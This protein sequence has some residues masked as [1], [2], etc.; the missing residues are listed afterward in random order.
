MQLDVVPKKPDQLVPT[1]IVHQTAFWGS[2]HR[3]LGFAVDAFDLTLRP[4]SG[5]PD[6]SGD[7]L[8]MRLPLAD[9][10]EC[11]YV[12][13]GPEIAPDADHVGAFL[14]G[15]SRE[16]RP[17][18]GERCAFI[19]WDLPWT[20][21][22]ARH[23]DDFT[24]DGRWRGAPAVH[25]REIRMNFGTSDHNLHKAPRD[26]LPPD[27]LLI[28][29]DAP[30]DA[31][32][33]RMHHKTRYNVRL[34]ERHGVVVEEGTLADLPAWHEIYLETARRCA[35]EPLP[36]QHFR[37]LLTERA[38]GAASPVLSRLLLARLDGKLLAGLI[39]AIA[40]TR[41]TYL[42][43]ASTR[44]RP[45]AM[46]PH[47]VQW[48]AIRLARSLGCAEY[49]MFGVAPHGDANHPLA[50]VHRFKIGF[51]GRLVHREGC[52]DFPYED[53]YTDL[54]RWE[55]STILHRTVADAAT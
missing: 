3:R 5:D 52:W 11:A 39:L 19:R 4:S 13:F 25:L 17:M 37:A 48:A 21:L 6:A 2:V 51:G 31:L 22:H 28:D 20:S 24:S 45:D 15:L 9:G 46:A 7:F 29:L 16:L 40:P 30:E 38:A 1:P 12:P 42:Y 35:I 23:A 44:E 26:L 41:A 14:A 53:A 43:G 55:E 49:D 10:V 32:L 33:A 36:L 47:A 18:L 54:R 27:T 8:V 50:G 34:A